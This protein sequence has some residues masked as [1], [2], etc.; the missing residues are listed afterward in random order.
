MRFNSVSP[1]GIFNNQS[2]MF[3]DQYG[4]HSL[5]GGLLTPQDVSKVIRF[6]ISE[7]ASSINGQNLVVDDGWTL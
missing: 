7:D 4:A 1:G 3:I 5:S 6:L 2:E